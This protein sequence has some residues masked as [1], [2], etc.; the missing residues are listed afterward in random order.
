MFLHIGLYLYFLIK[1]KVMRMTTG[2]VSINKGLE[3]SREN[4]KISFLE[5]AR[6]KK[7]T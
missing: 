3:D 5:R 4:W 1:G 2:R 7:E 6:V